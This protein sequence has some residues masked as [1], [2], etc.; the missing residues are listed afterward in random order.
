MVRIKHRYLLLNFLYPTSSSTQKLPSAADPSLSLQFNAPT[1][2]TLTS[3]LLA[4]LIRDNVSTL[5]GDY[6]AGMASGSLKIMYLSN[7]TS[8]AIVRVGRQHYRLVWAALTMAGRLPGVPDRDRGYGREGG[9]G[10]DGER[11]REVVIRVVRVSG[12]VRKCEEEAMKRATEAIRKAKREGKR[13]IDFGSGGDGIGAVMRKDKGKNVKSIE[14]D[15]DGEDEDED[16][17]LDY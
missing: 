1:P 8:T 7:P 5:F 11:G 12:T 16:M 15:D 4:R 2:D 3:S 10:R 9:K 6:G 13:E 14:D 17:G